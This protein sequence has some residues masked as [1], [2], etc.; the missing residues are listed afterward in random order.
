MGKIKRF[1]HIALRC[2]ETARTHASF[3]V[4]VCGF[5]LF[6]AAPAIELTG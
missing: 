5:I 4:L 3:L 6:K 2:E 1:N